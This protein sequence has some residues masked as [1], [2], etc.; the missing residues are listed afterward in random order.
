[1]EDCDLDRRIGLWNYRTETRL[2]APWVN[3]Q[4]IKTGT[5]SSGSNA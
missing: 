1:M 4:E 2:T 3:G 5:S